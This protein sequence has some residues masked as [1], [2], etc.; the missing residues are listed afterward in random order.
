MTTRGTAYRLGRHIGR[1]ARATGG[2]FLIEFAIVIVVVVVLLFAIIDFGRLAYTYVMAE[3]GL[4]IAA[5]I[6]AVRPP[7]C[8]DVPATNVR[9]TNTGNFQYGNLCRI[10]SNV[11]AVPAE[12]VC[13]GDL[14]NPTVA[15]I[16][17][18]DGTWPGIAGIMPL[19]MTPTNLRFRYTPNENMGFLGGPYVPVVTVELQQVDFAYALPVFQLAAFA[20]GTTSTQPN[21]FELPTLSVSLP[22]E[23]LNNGTDG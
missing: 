22:G 21:T 8:P 4:Q 19:G 1:F 20:A 14:A 16:W 3:K 7:A 11:C 10:G 15:E 12:A 5:R 18:G 2:A 13:V 23:D 9:G 17:N 6:A